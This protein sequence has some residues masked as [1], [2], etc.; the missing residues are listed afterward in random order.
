MLLNKAVDRLAFAS[1]GDH[2]SLTAREMGVCLRFGVPARSEVCQSAEWPEAVTPARGTIV[3]VTGPSGS[4]KSRLLAALAD[5][6]PHS[7]LLQVGGFPEDVS[8]VDGVAP[9]RSLAEAVGILT[10]C[11]LG[12]PRLWLRRVAML[13]EGERFRASLARAISL[14][15]T[16][17]GEP[18]LCDE[19]GSSLHRR[20]ARAIA[21][22]LRK[23]VSREGLTLVVATA[24][25]DVEED[26]RPNAVIRLSR[27]GDVTVARPRARGPAGV[28]SFARG[29]RIEPG[30]LR[31]YASFASLHY[32]RRERIACVDSVFVLRDEAGEA[33]GVVVY[34]Y[35]PLELSRRNEATGGRFRGNVRRLNAEMRILRRL[36]IHPDVRG[37]GLGVRL[38]A[39]TL[40]RVGT[41]FVE[42][43][44]A[45]GLVNPV[46]DRAGMRAIG[47]CDVGTRQERVLGALR[48][49]GADPLSAEF[50]SAACRRP[51]VRRIVARAVFDWYRGGV[52][53][54]GRRVEAQGPAELATTFRQLVGSR[55]VYYLW[56]REYGVGGDGRPGGGGNGEAA[57]ST[58][59]PATRAR[60]AGVAL[61][62]PRPSSPCDVPGGDGANGGKARK[63]ESEKSGNGVVTGPRATQFERRA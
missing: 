55:P 8:V 54:A 23:L 38:V 41:P 16:T 25:A 34:G 59:V 5:R 35:P 46:F 27:R 62:P 60:R 43:L 37:C 30:T 21:F 39:E 1:D 14:H 20:L 9:A 36:I 31:D 18:L 40:P 7:R 29:L 15:R 49:L 42:C 4:G 28:P 56:S 47:L 11:G 2:K 61:R 48:S 33:L 58:C 22:N 13:S 17:A 51:E 63:R 10:A 57:L 26:L 45:M 3:L 19:F 6:H 24:H 53:S 12:E 50:V 44:A 32:R 52:V